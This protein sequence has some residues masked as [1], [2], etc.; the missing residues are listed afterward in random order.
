MIDEIQDNF[1]DYQLAQK[2]LNFLNTLELQNIYP[3]L[4]KLIKNSQLKLL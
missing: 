3:K 4:L 2:D 1:L